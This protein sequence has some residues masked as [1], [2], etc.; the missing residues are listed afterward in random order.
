[1][2]DSLLRGAR[3][4][5]APVQPRDLES[6]IAVCA[7]DPIAHVVPLQHLEAA[8]HSGVAAPGLWGVRRRSRLARDLEGVIWNGANLCAVLP[9]D[10]SDDAETLRADVAASV[11]ASLTR[12]AA[13][14]GPADA[15]L[16]LW[17]RI[18]PWWGPAREVRARQVSMAIDHGPR[19]VGGI[20]DDGV[21]LEAVRAARMEDYEDLL[22]ACVHMFVGEVGYD[23]MRH[24]RVAYEDRLRQLVRSRR[25]FVQFGRIGGRR[26]VVFKA[27]VGALGGGVAQLQGVWVHPT[28][29]GRGLARAGLVAVI[30]QARATIAP[31][32]SLY[33]NDFNVSAIAAYEA[34]GFRR[35]GAFATVMF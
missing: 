7:A 26:A 11:V 6:A 29:R 21:G 35:V 13:L 33:V 30:D 17:G 28:L 32:L 22:P 10:D 2:T 20:D 4:A 18:E 15:T 25:A 27:E 19:Y 9:P 16:D 23:P 1:M 3:Y 24:G 14:V 12:P 5:L 31:T 8:L 34:V